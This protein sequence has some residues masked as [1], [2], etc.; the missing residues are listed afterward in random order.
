M[1]V[2]FELNTNATTPEIV[3]SLSEQFRSVGEQV[4]DRL[5][6]KGNAYKWD[7]GSGIEMLYLPGLYNVIL[8]NPQIMESAKQEEYRKTRIPVPKL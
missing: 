7:L 3:K 1:T 8:V 4:F 6:S 5:I 2:A